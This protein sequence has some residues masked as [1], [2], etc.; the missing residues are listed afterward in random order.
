MKR[1]LILPLVLLLMAG[2]DSMTGADH[3]DSSRPWPG[4]ISNSIASDTSAAGYTGVEFALTTSKPFTVELGDRVHLPHPGL[5]YLIFDDMGPDSRCPIGVDCLLPGEVEA[6]FVLYT[7]HSADTPLVLTLPGGTPEALPLAR[8]PSVSANGLLVHILQLDPYPVASGGPPNTLSDVRRTVPVAT[9]VIESCPEGVEVC[10]PSAPPPM[11]SFTLELGSAHEI[12]SE[13]YLVFDGVSQDSRCPLG[14][15]CVRPGEFDA[16]FSLV[17]RGRQV[18]FTLSLPGGSA[19]ALPLERAPHASAFGRVVYLVRL[20]PYPG[21]G[22]R[23]V[24]RPGLR[25]G[26]SL[27]VA[28][29]VVKRCPDGVDVCGPK[30]GSYDSQGS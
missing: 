12:H 6:R 24:M 11:D 16:R 7:H 15:E 23:N 29:L 27:P 20:D 22:S 1:V 2:C 26:D 9:L 5:H 8:A 19:E 28:T 3:P 10:G 30:I 14:L 4:G 13:L 25:R 21:D 17:T 18:P